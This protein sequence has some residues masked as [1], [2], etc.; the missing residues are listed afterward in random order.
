MS[1]Q[2]PASG[3]SKSAKSTEEH[4]MT[5]IAFNNGIEEVV[6][7]RCI[8]LLLLKGKNAPMELQIIS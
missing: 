1:Q 7:D 6:C 8:Y 2:S 5:P 3:Q 4:R